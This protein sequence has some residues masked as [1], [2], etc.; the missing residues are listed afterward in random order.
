M[1]FQTW[2]ELK[3]VKEHDLI[4]LRALKQPAHIDLLNR[5][6]D[7]MATLNPS[8]TEGLA[9]LETASDLILMGHLEDLLTQ[10][11]SFE[12]WKTHL[13]KLRYPHT[14]ER[15]EVTQQQMQQ[16]P[17]PAGA[18][19]KFERRGDKFGAELKYFISNQADVIKL[20]ASLERVQKE[21][22]S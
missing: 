9:F 21:L 13:R 20:I 5:L 1:S 10:T 16:L 15:D 6:A 8:F 12:A 14:T 3:K 11:S 17:W 18:K 2:L 4:F 19:I 7:Q 22:K